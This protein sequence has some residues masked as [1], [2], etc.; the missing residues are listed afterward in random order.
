MILDRERRAEIEP[1]NAQRGGEAV[2]HGRSLAVRVHARDERPGTRRSNLVASHMHSARTM[3]KV[4]KPITVLELLQSQHTEVDELIEKLEDERGD[5]EETF[6]EL[7]DKLA[8]HAAIEE[9]IFYPAAMKADLAEML[10]ESVEEHLAIK[11]ILADMLELDPEDDEEEFD[12]KLA[13]LKEAVDHHA[14]EEEEGELFPKL[15]RTMSQDEQVAL[16]SECAALFEELLEQEPR[17]NIAAET[18]RA[19]PLPPTH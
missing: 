9:Q 15:K 4:A 17:N 6:R 5:R 18:D 7:A 8:A 10:H 1:A 19:A 16:A 3:K 14:H 12:A 2:E 11:R 13:V